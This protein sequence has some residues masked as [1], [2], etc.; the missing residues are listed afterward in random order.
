MTL[1]QENLIILGIFTTL[2][3][4][5]VGISIFTMPLKRS[6]GSSV[7][8]QGGTM[9]AALSGM[10]EK[11][12]AKARSSGF[13]PSEQTGL[14]GWGRDP[15]ASSWLKQESPA[16]KAVSPEAGGEELMVTLILMSATKKIVAINHKICQEGDMVRGEKVVAIKRDA[17]VL[18]KNGTR[19][20]LL[21]PKSVVQF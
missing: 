7:P 4:M 3:V 14:Q 13:Q 16:A 8:L 15:F 11:K 12:T 19:R 21:L 17:V 9:Q 10:S 18:E 6:P 2:F 5:L 1:K 20:L